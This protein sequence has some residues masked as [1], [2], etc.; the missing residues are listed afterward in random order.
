M[1]TL[2]RLTCAAVMML[3]AVAHGQDLNLSGEYEDKGT[4]VPG[5]ADTGPQEVSLHALLSLEF[6][7]AAGVGIRADSSYVEITQEQSTLTFRVFDRDG[8][9]TWR[10]R[11]PFRIGVTIEGPHLL[12][13]MSDP[14]FGDDSFDFILQPVADNRL[15]QVRVVRHQATPFGP[16]ARDVGTYLFPRRT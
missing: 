3:A 5:K 11:S 7:P 6:D 1:K 10:S 16:V 15:L 14:R 2:H 12:V 13:R 9:A 4:A 8:T